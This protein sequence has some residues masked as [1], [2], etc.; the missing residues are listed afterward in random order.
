MEQQQTVHLF[1]LDGMADWEPGFAIA[2]INHPAYQ[3]HPGRYG[4]RT[5]G[6]T[7][8]PIRSQ[9]GLTIVPDVEL[10]DVGPGESAMLILPG[11]FAWEQGSKRPRWRRRTSYWLRGSPSPR[12]AAQ[13]PGWPGGACWTNARTRAT[14]S[15]ISP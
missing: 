6:A 14:P 13:R 8:K 9:G 1:V 3:T 5:V 2:G 7:R 11:S 4:V 12:S 10:A 15:S